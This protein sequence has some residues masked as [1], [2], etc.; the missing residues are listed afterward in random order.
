MRSTVREIE[1]KI[2][3][4]LYQRYF[5]GAFMQPTTTNDLLGELGLPADA[6]TQT[7]INDMQKEGLIHGEKPAGD[8]YPRWIRIEN[9]GIAKVEQNN[10]AFSIQHHEIRFRLLGHLYE[11]HYAAK[12]EDTL[13]VDT[14]LTRALGLKESDHN[15]LLGDIIYL[16]RL[17]IVVGQKDFRPFPVRIKIEVNGVKEFERLVDRSLVQIVKYGTTA[18]QKTAAQEAMNEVKVLTKWQKFR[19]I[20]AEN[21]E[22][23]ELVHNIFK[24]WL[25]G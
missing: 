22:I 19:L 18:A 16:Y 14:A 25:G 8:R 17:R 4:H 15:L 1:L 7:V 21:R 24:S 23:I 10:A 11:H 2:L 13:L 20:V 9:K 5:E 6:V 12:T 3:T